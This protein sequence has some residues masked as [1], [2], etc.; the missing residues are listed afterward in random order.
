MSTK[1]QGRSFNLRA[2]SALVIGLSGLGLPPTGLVSHLYGLAPLSVTR[3]AWMSAHN[4]L[5]V[6]FVVFAAVHV[7]L[8]RRALLAHARAT[9]SQLRSTSRELVLASAVIAVTLLLFVGH[10]FHAG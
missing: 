2:F 3:H 9:A 8:N 10:A 4:A 1:Q 7:V 5:G 6:L